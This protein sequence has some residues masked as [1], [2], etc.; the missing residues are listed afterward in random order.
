MREGDSHVMLYN[1]C[2]LTLRSKP[3]RQS[4]LWC[5]LLLQELLGVFCFYYNLLPMEK[6]VDVMGECIRT[7]HTLHDACGASGGRVRGH[8]LVCGILSHRLL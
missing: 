4:H 3:L 1:R 5:I 8:L 2:C 7:C 6:V